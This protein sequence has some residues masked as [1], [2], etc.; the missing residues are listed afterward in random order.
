MGLMGHAYMILEMTMFI[1]SKEPLVIII[2]LPQLG[3]QQTLI[4][5]DS[6]LLK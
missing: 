2:I 5:L 1:N 3:D 6:F 4:E